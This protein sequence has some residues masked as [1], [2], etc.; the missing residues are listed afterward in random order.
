MKTGLFVSQNSN[1]FA[2]NRLLKFVVVLIGLCELFNVYT[3]QKVKNDQM[4]VLLPRGLD[5]KTQVSKQYLDDAYIKAFSKDVIQTAFTFHPLN[6]RSQFEDVLTLFAPEAYQEAYA[7]FYDLAETMSKANIS[8]VVHILTITIDPRKS[9]VE[10][11]TVNT[12]YKED[13]RL[14]QKQRK[15]V[16]KYTVRNARMYV[17]GITEQEGS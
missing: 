3:L 16:I 10:V 5:E 7:H 2:Q 9:V 14:E 15:Y 12:K 8:S 11:Q 13:K 17:L 4:V 6:V 1:L